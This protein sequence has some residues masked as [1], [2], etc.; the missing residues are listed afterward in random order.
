MIMIIDAILMKND[1]L[2]VRRI[3]LYHQQ[4]IQKLNLHVL[5]HLQTL[6]INIIDKDDNHQLIHIVPLL[7]ILKYQSNQIGNQQHIHD[8]HDHRLYQ[9]EHHPMIIVIDLN[10][11]KIEMNIGMNE[12]D[13]PIYPI[14]IINNIQINYLIDMKHLIEILYHPHII[15]II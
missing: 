9:V 14:V 5:V 7:R 15:N 10:K 4:I 1:E 6:K 2:L 12:N 11:I 13:H 3:L 8:H